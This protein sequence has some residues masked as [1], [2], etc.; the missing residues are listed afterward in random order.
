MDA[1]DL[2]TK[3]LLFSPVQRIQGNDA[4]KHVFFNNQMRY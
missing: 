2:L 1:M 4:L 3:L